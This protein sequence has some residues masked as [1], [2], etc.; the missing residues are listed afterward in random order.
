MRSPR[1]GGAMRPSRRCAEAV[2]LDSKNGPAHYDL[3]TLLVEAGATA[4]AVG[5]FRAALAL[6]PGSVDVLNNL[7]IA[8]GSLGRLDEAI[9]SFE[10]ALSVR[11]DFPPARQNLAAAR[12]L[13]RQ[14]ASQRR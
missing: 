2:Q 11:P 13:Q 8:L 1:P 12:Q 3:A 9:E 6:M 14:L 5:E 10:R 7:G 4:E